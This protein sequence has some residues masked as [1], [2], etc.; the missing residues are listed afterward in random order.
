MMSIATNPHPR[1]RLLASDRILM[2][3]ATFRVVE[4]T[5]D[6]Y[7]L[8]RLLG[9]KGTPVVFTHAELWEASKDPDWRHDPEHFDP[10]HT[11]ARQLGA[12][13]NLYEQAE[14]ET[15]WV[16][17][18]WQCVTRFLRYEAEG[19]T[20]R[21]KDQVD[22]SL[23]WIMRD[24]DECQDAQAVLTKK[25]NAS[26]RSAK[27]GTVKRGARTKPSVR[28][29]VERQRRPPVRSFL[30]WLAAF[31]KGGFKPWALRDNYKACGRAHKLSE[32]QLEFVEKYA[33]QYL[34]INKPSFERLHERMKGEVEAYNKKLPPEDWIKCPSEDSIR[35]FVAGFSKFVVYACRY[36]EDRARARFV[37]SSG[38]Q[39]VVRP[40]QRVE[41][42]HYEADL[43]TIIRSEGIASL[44]SE[45][46]A[47]R[48]GRL[49]LCVALDVATK[50]LLGAHLSET[51]TVASARSVLRMAVTDKSE[52]ARDVGAESH[53]DMAANL[54]VVATDAGVAFVHPDFT[55]PI[56]DL[57]ATH[58]VP[59][60]GRPWLRGPGERVFQTIHTGFLSRFRGRTFGNYMKRRGHNPEDY[61]HLTVDEFSTLLIR[62]IVD[63]YHNTPH[64]GLAGETPRNAWLRLSSL[65]G[66]RP[67]P[68]RSKRLAIFGERL[69]RKLS[70]A[71]IELLGNFY[72]DER[73]SAMFLRKYKT[74]VE[75]K[76]DPDDL[77]AISFRDEDGWW[78]AKCVAPCFDKVSIETWTRTVRD[79]RATYTAEAQKTASVV[80]TAL[81]VIQAEAAASQARASIANPTLTAVDIERL[82]DEVFLGFHMPTAN[83]EYE[84]SLAP[85]SAG[86]LG[87]AFETGGGIPSSAPSNP[88]LPD[89][90]ASDASD[91]SN[92][93]FEA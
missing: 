38:G 45:E 71:G 34:D 83:L 63:V 10:D 39:D 78:E 33:R 29:T 67:L 13:T 6:G 20:N 16:F 65:V 66:T 46:Q 52:Y 31:E 11:K 30:R 18:K 53:W 26:K 55:N 8:D 22:R 28:G 50:C 90:T 62:W 92:F 2:G 48:I 41:I 14:K 69:T 93:S 73:L 82:E 24:I 42:D 12:G 21:S 68:D 4:K 25:L 56:Y 15:R 43:M 72:Q 19:K 23:S 84:R 59:P 49:Q 60:G 74:K 70:G 17:F 64:D 58:F 7:V 61:A 44:L 51:A 87:R 47:E 37:L 79:L 3:G 91:D 76:V 40:G 9:A 54:E 5:S 36:G 32:K 27:P 57:G 1:L 35:R 75:I 88:E 80:H 89:A 81:N 86:L 85:E 77:G